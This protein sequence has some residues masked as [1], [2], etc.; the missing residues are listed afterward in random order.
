MFIDVQVNSN[1]HSSGICYA[2]DKRGWA[3]SS[4]PL[5]PQAFAIAA[6]YV[7]RHNRIHGSTWGMH[8]VLSVF[9]RDSYGYW[10]A[11]EAKDGDGTGIVW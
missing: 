8:V 10:H 11:R 7:E 2:L 9:W 5:Y 1:V 4:K 6:D 3:D